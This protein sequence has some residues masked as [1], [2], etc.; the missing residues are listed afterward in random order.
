[1]ILKWGFKKNI[2]TREYSHMIQKEE[3][4]SRSSPSK[5][6]KFSLRGLSVKRTKIERFKA[7]HPR[8]KRRRS[9]RYHM[10][11]SV[12]LTN[13]MSATP[14]SIA[15]ATETS[16]LSFQEKMGDKEPS[17]RCSALDSSM[18]GGTAPSRTSSQIAR[19]LWLDCE[20]LEEHPGGFIYNREPESA[21]R[22]QAEIAGEDHAFAVH[23][24]TQQ[25]TDNSKNAIGFPV[26]RSLLNLKSTNANK[27]D[28]YCPA[29]AHFDWWVKYGQWCSGSSDKIVEDALVQYFQG[30]IFQPTSFEADMD[31]EEKLHQHHVMALEAGI[32]MEFD[33]Q[34]QELQDR[35][36][37]EANSSVEGTIGPEF[38]A[39]VSKTVATSILLNRKSW[40]S[41]T[42]VSTS[43][44]YSV[45]VRWCVSEFMKAKFGVL[46]KSKRVDDW[47]EAIMFRLDD[48]RVLAHHGR[49]KA[50]EGFLNL[51]ADLL[52][53]DSKQANPLGCIPAASIQQANRQRFYQEPR[54]TELQGCNHLMRHLML[55]FD[56]LSTERDDGVLD[57]TVQ[58]L[59]RSFENISGDWHILQDE[60]NVYQVALVAFKHV[61][62]LRYGQVY[63]LNVESFFITNQLDGLCER[64]SVS[65]EVIEAV[66][67][68][69]LGWI[70]A[71]GA[72]YFLG[73]QIQATAPG[74][75]AE[76]E[77]LEAEDLQDVSEI[78]SVR[79]SQLEAAIG[80]PNMNR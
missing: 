62:V 33:P 12:F 75:S 24:K 35:L 45:D 13:L 5:R 58:E 2:T 50:F 23:T 71:W 14:S 78:L 30:L 25:P 32:S 60:F 80:F 27:P 47:V 40:H 26:S 59:H 11:S 20:R 3:D 53:G 72:I 7:E 28:F 73:P 21:E 65:N 77:F 29:L 66:G 64:L 61:T 17:E 74:W 48:C 39:P 1:M 41:S 70:S 4:R 10:S 76:F 34:D 37:S 69:L 15:Y 16:E 67:Q 8:L 9:G 54:S 38:I 43:S 55:W 63:P 57:S 42:Q 44:S 46:S 52:S 51:M 68:E 18:I 56:P 49:K 22:S 6:T 79:W 31:H 36:S 19:N